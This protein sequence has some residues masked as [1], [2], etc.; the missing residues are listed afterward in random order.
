MHDSTSG[1]NSTRVAGLIAPGTQLFAPPACGH[2]TIGFLA[3]GHELRIDRLRAR[4]R[5][6][7]VMKFCRAEIDREE[8]AAAVV[9]VERVVNRLLAGRQ[10]D[11]A[12]A[13]VDGQR[14][15]LPLERPVEIPL[16]V[17]NVLEVPRELARV[18]IER[19]RRVV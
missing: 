4:A 10:H 15:D 7:A 2:T 13:A 14:D 9:E 18:G 1:T 11:A 17:R 16:V 3:R 12:R 19:D 5:I 8:I 6:D